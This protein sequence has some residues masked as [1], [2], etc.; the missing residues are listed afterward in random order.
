MLNWSLIEEL[1]EYALE[2]AAAREK[3]LKFLITTNGVGLNNEIVEYMKLHN[4]NVLV[5]IDGDRELHNNL[6][7]CKE[8]RM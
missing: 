6:R 7:P 5:S 8:T 4:F 1:T 3:E 2:C